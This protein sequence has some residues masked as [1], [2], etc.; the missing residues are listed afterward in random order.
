MGCF[1]DRW[2]AHYER[3]QADREHAGFSRRAAEQLAKHDADEAMADEYATTTDYARMRRK[4]G[5]E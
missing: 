5:L 3:A 2:I 1:K 4:E